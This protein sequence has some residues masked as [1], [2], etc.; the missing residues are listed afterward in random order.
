MYLRSARVRNFK[1][2]IDSGLANFARGFSVVVGQNNSG[3]TAFLQAI[4]LDFQN[5]PNR[6]HIARPEPV[7][8]LTRS[9]QQSAVQIDVALSGTQFH[10]SLLLYT[11]GTFCLPLPGSDHPELRSLF[12]QTPVKLLEQLFEREELIFR[13]KFTP[14]ISIPQKMGFKLVGLLNYSEGSEGSSR[15]ADIF[16][17]KNGEFSSNGCLNVWENHFGFE[18]LGRSAQDRI[19]KFSSDRVHSG[20]CEFGASGRLQDDL[21]NLPEVLHQLQE[22]PKKFQE[23]NQLVH[24]ILPIVQQVTVSAVPPNL[25]IRVWNHPAE[26]MRKD[27]AIS[28]SDCGTGVG[29][30]L[31]MLYLIVAADSDRTFL[32]DEPT[33]FLHP[34]A[35]RKLIDVMRQ[36]PQN[37]YIIS[38]HSP[39][40][41]SWIEPET[42]TMV[43]FVSGSSSVRC[44]KTNHRDELSLFLTEVGSS[45]GDVFGAEAIIWVEGP[46]EQVCFPLITKELLKSRFTG[47]LFRGVHSTN[48]ILGKR[49]SE[50]VDIYNRLSTSA[51]LVAPALSFIF[52]REQRTEELCRDLEKR[53]GVKLLKRRMYENYL[54]CPKAISL[55]VADWLS[56]EVSVDSVSS[57]LAKYM[58]DPTFYH[59]NKVPVNDGEK[60]AKVQAADLLSKIFSELSQQCIEYRKVEHG[61]ALTRIIIQISPENL[62]EVADL[63]AAVLATSTSNSGT[64]FDRQAHFTG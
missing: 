64:E 63:L 21:T 52:D 47:L 4:S 41:V 56:F 46:T 16:V 44:L 62:R 55:L 28:L 36:Y 61:L 45:L 3:K 17:H 59:P 1:S 40:V 39:Q 34:G 13:L 18:D 38:T 31:A 48:Q 50:I 33:S 51:T 25:E 7:S 11:G 5:Q 37:Q 35:V 57:L 22:N 8:Q 2:F 53:K 14:S 42:I 20:T 60:V 29:H 6:S 24:Y 32:I 9:P 10:Q 27:L 58:A 43:Q 54:L 26:S 30:V 19:Y 15:G 23:F 12:D 49:A